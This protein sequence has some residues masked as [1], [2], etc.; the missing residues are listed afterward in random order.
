L[1]RLDA[2]HGNTLAAYR[3]MGN[4]IYSTQKQIEELNRAAALPP[5]EELQLHGGKLNLTLPVNALY[6]L[7]I[8]AR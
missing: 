4:P 5:P 3:A 2:D 1:S 8:P 7:E 6:I